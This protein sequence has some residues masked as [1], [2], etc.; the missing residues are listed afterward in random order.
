MSSRNLYTKLYENISNDYILVL[1]GARQTGKTY[2]LNQLKDQLQ[3]NKEEVHYLTLEDPSLLESLDKHPEE[4][5]KYVPK[6]ES[7]KIFVLIDEIQYLSNPSNFLKYIYDKYNTSIKL[8]VTGSSAFYIDKHFKDSLAGRKRIFELYTFSFKEFLNAKGYTKYT[9]LFNSNYIETKAKKKFLIPQKKELF[10]LYVEY[11][12][13]G[14]YPRVILTDSIE[15]KKIILKELHTSFLKKD[16]F[17]SGIRNDIAAYNLLKLLASQTGNL[18]NSQELANTLNISHTSIRNYLYIL[19]KSFIVKRCLPF[20]NNQRKELSKMPKLF[21]FDTGLRNSILS[22]FDNFQKR[23]DNGSFLE[24]AFYKNLL[25]SKCDTINFWRTQSQNEVDFV[26][27]NNIAFEIKI[28]KNRFNI[29][30][31]KKFIDNY[32]NIDLKL[33][34]LFDEKNLDIMD[35]AI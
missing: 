26:L 33:V 28:N 34:T 22:N 3:L 9:E 35:F 31:Y 32:P 23:A 15:E 7:S 17:E 19:E 2:L 25:H 18:I 14:G 21:F 20:F 12:T 13:F 11:I 5:F 6:K 29:N 30:K 27:N 8:V 24:N 1:I 4:L 10:N 16:F